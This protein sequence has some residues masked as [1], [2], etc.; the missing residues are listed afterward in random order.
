MSNY[1]ENYMF[2]NLGRLGNDSEDTSQKT[3]YNARYS[4]YMLTNYFSDNQQQPIEF[5]TN[6]P[7]VTIDGTWQGPGLPAMTVDVDSA[8][9]F[10]NQSKERPWE[11][12]EVYPRIFATVPY[13]GRGS[14]DP[15]LENVIRAGEFSIDRKSMSEVSE[16]SYMGHS[17][18]PGEE[19]RREPQEDS[20]LEFTHGGID[21]RELFLKKQTR[22]NGAF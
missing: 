10:R 7:A 21:S 11:K 12:M 17:I 20:A 3:V 14:A 16:V 22:P 5:S 9:T 19:L 15:T 6:Q 13:L 18:Y 1:E 4:D 8:L 2:N